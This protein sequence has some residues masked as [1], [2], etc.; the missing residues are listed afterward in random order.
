M[1]DLTIDAISAA[2]RGLSMR[3]QVIAQNLANSETPGYTAG[4]VSF[5]DQLR[6]AIKAGTPRSITPTVA[7]SSAAAKI[8]GNNVALDDE[9]VALVETGL[10][11]QLMS[12]AA[13]NKFNIIRAAIGRGV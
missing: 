4:V 11:Y 6:D 12:Q 1:S 2:L 5:E 8:D 13:T 7:A 9:T 3:Q 10:R